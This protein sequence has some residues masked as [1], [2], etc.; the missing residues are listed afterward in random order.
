MIPS[1]AIQHN[2]AAFVYVIQDNTAH[3]RSVKPGVTEAG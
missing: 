2:G 3:M 1:S